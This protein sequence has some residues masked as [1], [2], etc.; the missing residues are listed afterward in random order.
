[1]RSYKKHFA[2]AIKRN[3]PGSFDEVA[4]TAEKNYQMISVDSN[5]SVR[6]KN[7]IDRRLDFCAYFLALIK[8]LDERGEQYETIKRV[9][10]EVV[11]D[12]ITPKN[13]FQQMMMRI[14]PKLVGTGLWNVFIN[15]LSKKSG[16]ELKQGRLHCADHYQ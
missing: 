12:Y 10:L 14:R 13:K 3:Y 11:T 4:S 16:R 15:I 8:T 7:P 9:S 1:M 5:F 2:K 6:S